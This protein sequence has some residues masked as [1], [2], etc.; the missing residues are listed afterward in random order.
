MIRSIVIRGTNWIGDSIMSIPA[1]RSL[2][3]AFPDAEISLLT[4]EWATG[5]FRDADFVDQII[6]FKRE[7]GAWRNVLKQAELLRSF[8]FDLA[9]IFPNS[10][11]S[12]L[13]AKLAGIPHRIGYNK[14]LRG[15]LL[16]API[17]VPEWKGRRHET[18]Y[19]LNLVAEAQ[20]RFAGTQFGDV[21]EPEWFLEIS[22]ERKA[23]ARNF[24]VAAGVDRRRPTVALGVGS[25]N[26]LA[27]RWG[28]ERFAALNDLIRS[29]LDANVILIG[30]KDESDVAAAVIAAARMKPIDLTGRTDIEM[31]S[32]IL[33]VVDLLVSNDMG[34][35]HIA[36]AAG[37]PTVV[38]FGPTND[39]TTRPFSPFASV[40]RHPVECS[41]CMLR[42]CPIDHRCMT[43]LLP[44][45]VF[46]KVKETLGVMINEQTGSIH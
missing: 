22:D 11:E 3:K 43:R 39:V 25:T 27:K 29:E 46:E 35:A 45:D 9:V 24:L 28:T 32:S 18:Y 15:L 37:T 6:P 5:I 44:A 21:G 7:K 41:P 17:A 2:S 10:F 34:T 13:S 26:S 33:A 40:I 42:E 16:S 19:Y 36:P 30:T 14:D 23:A 12:A 38:I 4:P 31:A 20:R 1:M 8:R